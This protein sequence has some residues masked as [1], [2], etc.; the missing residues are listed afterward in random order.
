MA[1][2]YDGR[3]MTYLGA[4]TAAARP[5][6]PNTAPGILAMWYATDTGVFSFWESGAGVWSAD[7]AP[8]GAAGD[9]S[10]T[11][12]G[13][14]VATDVQA[15][16]VELDSEKMPK[17]GGTFTGDIIVPD[18]VYDAT[19]WNGNFEVPT[20]NAIRD[21]FAV[22]GA[23]Y[24]DEQAQDAVGGMVDSTLT[25]NDGT[26]SLGLSNTAVTPA[27][28]TKA[29][30]TVDQQGRVTAAASG[31]VDRWVLVETLA[32]SAVSSIDSEA[33][34]GL[35]Y[36]QIKFVFDLTMSS[37]GSFLAARFKQNAAYKTAANYRYTSA[38]WSTGGTS[39]SEANA[40][41]DGILLSRSG[42][43]WGIGNNTL[44]AIAGESRL[45]YPDNTGKPK[46]LINDA[47]HAVPSG[48]FVRIISGGEYEG[49]DY[50]GAVQGIRLYADAG[51]FTGNIAVYALT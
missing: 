6:T 7:F 31:A 9:V 12:A 42:A 33:W 41:A 43:T 23:G 32:P 3:L 47:F 14:L 21:V 27:A 13:D 15:A 29:S 5:A 51:T 49:T 16:L 45:F 25:Y 50:S 10:F 36:K 44:E 35:G 34:A 28:Y 17:A 37:D 22:M 1:A 24:T 38:A 4:G 39:G 8:L 19:A 30:V 18:E 26:P 20:K 11:P 40:A 46:R 2:P 48:Q